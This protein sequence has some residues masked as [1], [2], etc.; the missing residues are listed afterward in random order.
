MPAPACAM[1]LSYST[2]RVCASEEMAPAT[3]PALQ[4]EPAYEMPLIVTPDGA[5][6]VGVGAVEVVVLVVD[7]SVVEVEVDVLEEE[8]VVEDEEE[9]EVVEEVDVVVEVVLIVLEVLV[10]LEVEEEVF[11]GVG[12]G[13]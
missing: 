5:D 7:V 8:V 12:L 1:K 13:P 6:V 3:L 11:V 4:P 2:V 9:D 10:V